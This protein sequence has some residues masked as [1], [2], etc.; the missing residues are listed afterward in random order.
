MMP[1][2]ATYVVDNVVVVVVVVHPK[3][4]YGHA[5]LTRPPIASLWHSS[6]AFAYVTQVGF[7]SGGHTDGGSVGSKVDAPPSILP[8][9]LL[10]DALLLLLLLPSMLC[11]YIV[12][13]GS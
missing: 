7:S 13:K 10:P 6:G 3:H 9:P 12:I 4:R 2:L 11:L 5:C 8:V 1:Y